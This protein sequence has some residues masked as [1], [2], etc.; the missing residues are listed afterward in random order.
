[1]IA[2]LDL[3]GLRAL[4]ELGLDR[5]LVWLAVAVVM[6]ASA[7]AGLWVEQAMIAPLRDWP[8]F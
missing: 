7:V 4:A 2:Y 6:G 1:M 5:V 8:G 3:H